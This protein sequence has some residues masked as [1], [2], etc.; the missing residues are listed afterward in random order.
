MTKKPDKQTRNEVLKNLEDRI[1][2]IE[3]TMAKNEDKIS[4]MNNDIRAT[5]KTIAEFAI[6]INE[7]KD[8]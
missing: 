4:I 3:D 5:A 1:N 7:L 6:E 8:R 2:N